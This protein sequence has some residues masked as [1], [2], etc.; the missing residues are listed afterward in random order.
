MKRLIARATFAMALAG[1]T[2]GLHAAPAPPPK[3][4]HAVLVHGIFQSGFAYHM[5]KSRL[6]KQ[7]IEVLVP[8]LCPCDGRGGLDQIAAGLKR[9]IDNAFGPNQRIALI[10]FSMGGIVSRYYLQ[11]LGGAAR[12]DTFITI[13]SPHHGTQVAWL[14]P[15]K[16]AEQMR[17]GSR[18]LED[19]RKSESRLG[20][21]P[22]VSYHTPLDLV[23]VPA[24]SSVWERAE[25]VSF[26]VALH[27]LMLYSERVLG[28]IE[29]RLVE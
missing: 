18:F 8:K 4:T 28:D 19:L 1:S 27:P 26:N 14:Y 9:D 25:N 16:G 10:G 6:Q 22:V 21:I 7:G 12:C 20:R 3:V 29:R 17:P 11:E 23:I 15:T 24:N 5:L 13:S 2:N